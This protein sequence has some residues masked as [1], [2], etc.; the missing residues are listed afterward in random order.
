MP[1]WPK[2]RVRPARRSCARRPRAARRGAPLAWREF[3]LLAA[4]PAAGPWRLSCPS[5]VLTLIRPDP[6]S[7][8]IPRT[9]KKSR[10]TGTAGSCT[11]PPR[12]SSTSR[13]VSSPAM[14]LTPGKNRQPQ[15]APTAASRARP[16]PDVRY[17]PRICFTGRSWPGGPGDLLPLGPR[18]RPATLRRR[19]R[20]LPRL[21]DR[22][23][24]AGDTFL[25]L[26]ITS[27]GS[28][29]LELPE[30]DFTAQKETTRPSSQAHCPFGLTWFLARISSDANSRRAAA[31]RRG[32]LEAGMR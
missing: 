28:P 3:R 1:G 32:G 8:T 12:L 10:P 4:K 13:P 27:F 24:A 17:P 14:S 30:H 29:G 21:N 19:H 15:P 25:T 16:G 2:R 20:R 7:A 6:N 23:F 31:S 18:R 9:L 11:E 22:P 26:L 5:R